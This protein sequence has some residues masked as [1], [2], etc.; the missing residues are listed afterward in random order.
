MY[1]EK[2]LAVTYSARS[3]CAPFWVAAL[4]HQRERKRRRPSHAGNAHSVH[5]AC[6][7]GAEALP[8]GHRR[9]QLCQGRFPG[10]STQG[11]MALRAEEM[12]TGWLCF[13]TRKGA[14]C[15]VAKPLQE[16]VDV[17]AF[18]LFAI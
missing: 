7:G 5:R 4:T 13:L 15:R 18:F 6:R 11:S 16:G 8:M 14:D 1:V 12:P 3:A 17:Q 2:S 9:L 10:R